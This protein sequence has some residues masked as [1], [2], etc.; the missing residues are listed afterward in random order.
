[1][2]DSGRPWGEKPDRCPVCARAVDAP[3][4]GRA[5]CPG[6]GHLLWFVSRQVAD[7][8]VIHLIDSRPAVMEMLGVLDNAV[9]DGLIGRMVL[10]LG[11]IPQVSSAALG[12]LVKLKKR[13]EAARGKLVLCGLSP[14][15]RPAFRITR[16]DQ[17]FA[18]H[19]TEAEALAALGVAELVGS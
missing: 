3:G 17:A 8:T 9:V 13:A 2:D 4:E 7:V 19:E 12:K 18:I 16:L 10:N 14:E 11:G 6:C 1:M 15:L 5:P